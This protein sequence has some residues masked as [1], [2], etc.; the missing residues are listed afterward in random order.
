[1]VACRSGKLIS[2]GMGM[3]GLMVACRS[4]KLIYNS[5]CNDLTSINILVL[6]HSV[7]KMTFSQKNS[8]TELPGMAWP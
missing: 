2:D 7:G 6:Q 3:M 8:V 4:G 5:S 1:M